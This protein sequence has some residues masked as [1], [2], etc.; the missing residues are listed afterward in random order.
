MQYH[1]FD[2]APLPAMAHVAQFDGSQGSAEFDVV[3]NVTRYASAEQQLA[4][5]A[6]A[7]RQALDA[8]GLEP[9]T[10]VLRRFYC[11]DLHNQAG[12][13]HM[14][15]LSNPELGES[16]FSASYV[17]QPPS[18]PARLVL[19]AYHMRPAEGGLS[20]TRQ[21]ATVSVRS[22]EQDHHWTAGV[23]HPGVNTSYGQTRGIFDE[24]IGFLRANG[25][26]LAGNV[27]RTWIHVRNVD[28]NYQGMVA[29]RRE[30][31][32]D[33]NLTPDTHY[34]ASTGIEGGAVAIGAHVAMDAYAVG[35]LRSGQ[36]EY[37]AALDH[38]GPTHVYGVTFERA[39]AVDYCDR[40][41]IFVSGTASIDPEGR[42]LHPGDVARQLDRAVENTSALLAAGGAGLADFGTVIA[43]VR[44]PAD[45]ALIE[46][47]MREH[48]PQA[49]VAVLVAP[50]CRPGWLVEI[51]GRAILTA[52]HPTLPAY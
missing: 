41:H 43:Y 13:L 44:D 28:A 24:Y 32:A 18:P 36:V 15:P 31:F 50:V 48:F 9:G 23:V 38:L 19:W 8:V 16:D 47:R 27:V 3:V 11:S 26:T 12:A 20:K 40:R 33:H 29:A 21:G 6:E 10:V 35:G 49:P 17:C 1:R 52:S 7:Y 39:T 25:M 51:E 2:C 42:I 5:L 37:L 34:I 46:A 22:T 45:Q 30:I 4:W 14:H